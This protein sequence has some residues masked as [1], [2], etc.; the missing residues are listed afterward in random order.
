MTMVRLNEST[1]LSLGYDRATVAALRH[2]MTQVGSEIGADTLPNTAAAASAMKAEII[3]LQ[4]QTALL[5]PQVAVLETAV[6]ALEV[7]AGALELAVA[8][9]Q[10]AIA[11]RE[12]FAESLNGSVQVLIANNRALAVRIDQ[13]EDRNI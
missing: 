6:A 4:G 7:R 9:L 2:V 5:V 1:L 10:A 11:E 3:V 13:L 8:A 12:A